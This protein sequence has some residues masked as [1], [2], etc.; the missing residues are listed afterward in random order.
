MTD[1][2]LRSDLSFNFGQA[3][4]MI[5]DENVG[6]MDVMTQMLTGFGFRKFHRCQSVGES[7]ALSACVEPD[8][9]LV[10][11]FPKPEDGLTFIQGLRA[12]QPAEAPA[13]V[14]I[15][16]T[17]HTPRDLIEKARRVGAD[18]VVAKPFSPATLLDRILWSAAGPADRPRDN[19]DEG[20]IVSPAMESILQASR[21]LLS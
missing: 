6:F 14:V 1:P 3:N 4:V 10:D 20:K 21:A 18:Y 2:A 15:V 16:M 13:L 19:D 9:I 8:L 17:G 12:R 7:L 5:V 11:P